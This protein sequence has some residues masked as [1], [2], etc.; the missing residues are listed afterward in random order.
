M[1]EGISM[2]IT[3][4]EIAE[5]VGVSRQAVS[6]VLNGNPGKVSAEKRQRI[7]HIAKNMQYKPNQAALALAGKQRRK[8]IGIDIGFF[9]PV[10]LS[11]M[12]KMTMILLG[13]GCDIRLTP[14]GDKKHKI[15][16]LYDLVNEGAVGVVSDLNSE[17]FEV[18]HFNCPLV[19]LGNEVSRCDISYGYRGGFRQAVLHLA[20]HGH[21]RIGYL[22]SHVSK[23]SASYDQHQG[24]L[25]GLREAGLEESQAWVVESLWR[26]DILAVIEKIIRKDKVSAFVC[27]NDVIAAK[28]MAFLTFRGIKIP[29]SVAVI[30]CGASFMT[31]TAVCPMT[32]VSLPVGHL[33]E[34]MVAELHRKMENH[35]L[36][37]SDQPQIIETGLYLGGSCGCRKVEPKTIYW[38]GVPQSLEDMNLYIKEP[39]PEYL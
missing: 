33:A 22:C 37:T 24:Y 18:D 26:T 30:G 32:S 3:T 13:E 5:L 9:P 39:P 8:L 34:A 15:Q 14:P 6:A 2:G 31:E 17:I 21:R 38:E 4:K 36:G 7:L 16:I 29:E 28:L 25:S 27:E 11:I 35:I 12:E 19:L 10:K 23:I 1:I 20:G